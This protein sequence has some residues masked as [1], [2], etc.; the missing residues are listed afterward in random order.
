MKTVSILESWDCIAED[1]WCR[2]LRLQ[3]MSGGMSD[4]YSFKSC[5]S[6]IP[7]NNVEWALVKHC[8]GKVW[9]GKTVNEIFDNIG[10]YEF[11]RGEV[12]RHHQLDMSDYTVLTHTR[13]KS[14]GN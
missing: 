11:V 14:D 8:F 1:D 10:P 3:S 12:P 4:H 5:Y 7:E 6:G 2:P 13:R 9:F